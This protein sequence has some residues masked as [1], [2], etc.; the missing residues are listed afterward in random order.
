MAVAAILEIAKYQTQYEHRLN[1]WAGAS[2]LAHLKGI[3]APFHKKSKNVEKK[4]TKPAVRGPLSYVPPLGENIKMG[5]KHTLW[6]IQAWLKC[7][8]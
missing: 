7:L 5:V 6:Y 8:H 4:T 1:M 2:K 3:G